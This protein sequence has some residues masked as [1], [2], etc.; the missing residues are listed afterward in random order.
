MKKI[1]SH[2]RHKR[3]KIAMVMSFIFMGTVLLSIFSAVITNLTIQYATQEAIAQTRERFF[4]SS[5]MADYVFYNVF[6]SCYY[7][8]K[9]NSDAHI[10]LY[11]ESF[12][13]EDKN[14]LSR[15]Y[16]NTLALSDLIESVYFVNPNAGVVCSSDGRIQTLSGFQDQSAVDL[17]TGDTREVFVIR[18]IT[19]GSEVVSFAFSNAGNK[20]SAVPGGMVV[21]L[22]ADRIWEIF[23]SADVKHNVIWIVTKSGQLLTP[24]NSMVD[25]MPDKE[26]IHEVQAATREVDY[27]IADVNGEKSMVVFQRSTSFG[28]CFASV[29]PYRDFTDS[30]ILLRNKMV[31]ITMC[32]LVIAIAAAL[33][34]TRKLYAPIHSLVEHVSK[35][36][37]TGLDSSEGEYAY[38]MNSYRQ[39]IDA[40]NSTE[41]YLLETGGRKQQL[42]QLLMGSGNIEA[43]LEAN[44]LIYPVFFV[45]IIR[46][47]GMRQKIGQYTSSDIDLIKFG[48]S[49]VALEVIGKQ[50]YCVSIEN[51]ADY[52]TVVINPGKEA[53]ASEIRGLG[54]E[55][56]RQC[57]SALQIEITC[58]ISSVTKSPN[59][60]PTVYR[61]AERASEYEILL[62]AGNIVLWDDIS[63]IENQPQ[64]YPSDLEAQIKDSI[65]HGYFDQAEKGVNAFFEVIKAVNVQDG[66]LWVQQI[67]IRISQLINGQPEAHLSE[68]RIASFDLLKEISRFSTYDEMHMH[69]IRVI[70]EYIRP[71]EQK[72]DKKR[73]SVLTQALNYM[74]RN[75]ADPTLSAEDIAVH[76]GYSAS[77]LRKLFKD[78][79][80]C[81]PVDYLLN[82]RIC[83]AKEFLK[84]TN[85]SAKEIA[86]KVG[87]QNT[88]YFYKVFKKE[89]GFTATAYRENE[90]GPV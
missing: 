18:N 84:S 56:A 81:S 66:W 70:Y 34:L 16:R 31:L 28:L 29:I 65:I 50:F 19:D 74:E 3:V 44:G 51:G 1:I 80:D 73:K 57:G 67:A 33:L 63:K 58:A 38:L 47:F 52:I 68:N 22:Y 25:K 7:I 17:L 75:Y 76:A 40:A 83:K 15:L 69:L 86:E 46:I 5:S 32:T 55:V 88:K 36:S 78:E 82:L 89:T 61:Q 26:I 43:K 24:D 42:Y 53:T 35:T 21:N 14:K 79:Y 39:M 27:M 10:A 87:Y 72:R 85:L 60:I 8:Q 20:D 9:D 12:S 77:Y 48:L 54:R 2:I 90:K 45:M 41:Q 49:N 64:L 23:N 71:I 4:V 11:N 13:H 30:T 59:Q 62:G 37:Q 6:E